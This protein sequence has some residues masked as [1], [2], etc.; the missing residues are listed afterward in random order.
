MA[1]NAQKEKLSKQTLAVPLD[2]ARPLPAL[3]EIL[4]FL[5]QEAPKKLTEGSIEDF[6][7]WAVASWDAARVPRVPGLVV[8][9]PKRLAD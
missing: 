7:R 5:G 4:R 1:L 2:S 8:E 3:I 9:M 6:W